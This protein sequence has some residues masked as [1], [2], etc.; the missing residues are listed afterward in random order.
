MTKR[1]NGENNALQKNIN[2]HW[3]NKNNEQA[4][5][6]LRMNGFSGVLFDLMNGTHASVWNSRENLF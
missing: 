5:T 2:Y 1:T 4:E 6:A 3:N